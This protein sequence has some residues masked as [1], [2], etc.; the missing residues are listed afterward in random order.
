MDFLQP[1]RWDDALTALAERPGIVP[2][3]GATD[4]MVPWNTT[5]GRPVAA[6]D[7]GRVAQLTGWRRTGGWIRLS[8]M[9]SYTTVIEELGGVLPG[10][11]AAGATVGSRQIRNRGT[12][13][14]SLGTASPTGDA[15]TALMAC[16][17]RVELASV[18]GVREVPVREFCTGPGRTVREADELISAVLVPEAEGPQHYA[19]V[20]RRG[21]LVV[22]TCSFAVALWPS[23]GRV[24]TGLGAVAPTV[25]PA[26]GAERFIAAELAEYGLWHSRGRVPDSTLRRFGDLVA[27]A[28][29]P[30]DD[31]RGTSG[32][33][34][35]AIAV[36]ATRA[37]GWAWEDYRKGEAACAWRSR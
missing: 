29:V 34:R 6:L 32:Y 27:M 26:L 20:G 15:P 25:R 9:V 8:A 3:A 11:A 19:K 35:H 21:A 23:R 4:V 18:R 37:L 33:R 16:D 13:C 14:G 7:L 5:G 12:V 1:C 22:S 2:V 28:A 31:V 10:L 30:A 17:A 24:G 36:L